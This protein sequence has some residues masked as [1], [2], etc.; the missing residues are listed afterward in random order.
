MAITG[1]IRPPPDIR[2][3]ADKTAS[4]VAKK[5]RVFEARILSSAKGRTPQFA[6]LHESSPFHAY[7]EERIRFFEEGGEIST[8]KTESSSPAAAIANINENEANG[9]ENEGNET[10]IENNQTKKVVNEKGDAGTKDNVTGGTQKDPNMTNT[11][12]TKASALDPVAR[13]LL[14]KRSQIASQHARDTDERNKLE[15]NE[16]HTIQN[17]VDNGNGVTSPLTAKFVNLSAPSNCTPVQLDV[18][19]LVAQFTALQSIHNDIERKM[20]SRGNYNSHHQT[21]FDESFLQ[22]LTRR[23]WNNHSLAFVQP[24]HASFAYFIA[25]VDC[26]KQIILLS[27][28]SSNLSSITKTFAPVANNKTAD[29]KNDVNKNNIVKC[30]NIAAYKAEFDR[31]VREQ[32]QKLQDSQNNNDKLEGSAD[33]MIDWHDFVVVETIDFPVDE[34]VAMLPPPPPP[35]S[36]R[37]TELP[38]RASSTPQNAVGGDDGMEESSDE[39]M[40]EGDDDKEEIRIDPTYQPR[41]VSSHATMHDPSRTHVVD[42]I[43]GKSVPLSQMSE[44]LRIQLLDPKWA[45][46]KAKF[47]SKQKESNLGGDIARNITAFVDKK[48]GD[49]VMTNSS[50]VNN[51]NST[52]SSG[53]LFGAS[54]QER[55][56][57]QTE[58]RRRLENA[59]NTLQEQAL[60]DQSQSTYPL[61]QISM[62]QMTMTYPGMSTGTNVSSVVSH[63]LTSLQQPLGPYVQPGPSTAP[64]PMPTTGAMSGT[65]MNGI[66]DIGASSVLDDNVLHIN[67]KPR[68]DDVSNEA[69][70]MDTS[71][72]LQVNSSPPPSP[73]KPKV[74]PSILHLEIRVPLSSDNT[75]SSW[76]LNGQK[77]HLKDI[78]S[79]MTVQLIKQQ[80]KSKL[81]GEMPINKMQI[82]DD[83][84]GVFLK[85]TFQL[86]DCGLTVSTGEKV[87]GQGDD[88]VILHLVPKV[89]GGRK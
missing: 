28:K 24:R 37:T 75:N 64:M 8:T 48:R 22:E 68:L 42:P 63:P 81:G 41:V 4:Y 38:T 25:L 21:R 85:P 7:Y 78:S 11:F 89:R 65:D 9:K 66:N 19:K 49:E 62:P 29:K 31:D 67:K 47:Q 2:A 61:S 6:F 39:D 40:G 86:K 3:V 36:L 18:I 43:S 79:S 56:L 15:N 82:K 23:E 14:E 83:E 30:L 34:I 26:Y 72:E 87:E 33:A 32:K 16:Q 13:A 27:S 52:T 71:Q 84:S 60:L 77:I 59:N 80:I 73:V 88:I 55:D 74:L 5:G 12:S 46:E 54:E 51:R 58:E 50:V 76:N 69:N 20:R 45:E 70:Y 35:S 10:S 53:T 17:G 44:H 1:V 57:M